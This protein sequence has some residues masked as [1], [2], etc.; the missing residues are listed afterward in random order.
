MDNDKK[1]SIDGERV[2]EKV[3]LSKLFSAVDFDVFLDASANT[4]SLGV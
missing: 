4:L 3:M 2:K 1:L